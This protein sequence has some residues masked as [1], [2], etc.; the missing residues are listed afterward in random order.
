MAEPL[1]AKEA[2]GELRAVL[3]VA[4]PVFVATGAYLLNEALAIAL[5]GHVGPSEIL[6]ATSAEAVIFHSWCTYFVRFSAYRNK[7]KKERRE[8]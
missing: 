7:R 5:L 1:L 6:K 3:R 8:L 4:G 2:R